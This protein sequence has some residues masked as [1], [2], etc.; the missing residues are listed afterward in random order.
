MRDITKQQI[1]KIRTMASIIW[2][3]DDLYHD[4]LFESFK[5]A[6]TK[7]LNFS[8]ASEAIR[9]LSH[10]NKLF[11]HNPPFEK[12]GK[13]Y[14]WISRAQA[15][16]IAILE[17]ILGWN[18]ASTRLTGF[19]RRQIG[20]DVAVMDM[21]SKEARKVIIGMQRI[22]APKSEDFKCINNA[23][24]DDLYDTYINIKCGKK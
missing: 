4:W 9:I 18:D 13:K 1:K 14:T 22:V 19:I 21:S 10:D 3:D 8:E 12:K 23:S 15:E 5:V 24:N 7:D 11:N 16:R 6:S 17:V 2:G 20:D